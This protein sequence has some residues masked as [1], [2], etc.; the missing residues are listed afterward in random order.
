M[1]GEMM[2]R[3]NAYQGPSWALAI[4]FWRKVLAVENRGIPG[5]LSRS[6]ECAGGSRP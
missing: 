2:R 5:S 3:S 6:S 4:L 1:R